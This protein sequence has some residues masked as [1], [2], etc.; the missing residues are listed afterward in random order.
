MT[1]INVDANV[2]VGL[3]DPQD[4]WHVK[5][6]A[7]KQA[8]EASQVSIAISDCVLTEV[9]SVLARRCHEQRRQQNLKD[10]LTQILADYPVENILWLLP[11]VPHLY[12]EVVE[13]VQMSRGELNFNDALLAIAC[14]QRGFDMIASFDRDFDTIP[15]LRRIAQPSDLDES[16]KE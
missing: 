14:R 4:I 1:Q 12:T 2:I 13:L 11:D 15:W 9:I 16:S 8:L 5:A 6:V 3:L 7:L 10:L